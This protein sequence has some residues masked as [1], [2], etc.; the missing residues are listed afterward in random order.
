ML[1]LDEP[2]SFMDIESVKVAEKMIK[3]YNKKYKSTIIIVSHEEGQLERLTKNIYKLE[4]G[5]L[6]KGTFIKKT[7]IGDRRHL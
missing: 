1:I 4:N 5:K 6:K 3:E 7:N 2:T